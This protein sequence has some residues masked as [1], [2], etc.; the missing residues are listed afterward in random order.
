MTRPGVAIALLALFVVG[1]PAAA[2]TPK[3]PEVVDAV[4]DANGANG[5]GQAAGEP[6]A[7]GPDARPASIDSADLRGPAIPWPVPSRQ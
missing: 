1:L 5:Q 7:N 3:A 4:G 6:I 2:G